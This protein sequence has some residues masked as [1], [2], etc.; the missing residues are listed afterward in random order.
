MNK[1]KI[2]KQSIYGFTMVELLIVVVVL[3]LLTL[4]SGTTYLAT[5]KTA[6]DGKR[7]VDL[8]NIRSA[9]EV[10]KSD[11]STYPILSSGPGPSTTLSTYLDPSSGKKYI[12]MPTDPKN[13]S[14]YYYVQA[15]CTTFTSGQEV[16]NSYILAVTL[17]NSPSTVPSGTCS[18][19]KTPDGTAYA[20]RDTTGA[21]TK[22]SYCLDPY[23]QISVSASDTQDAIQNPG[24]TLIT[25][26]PN[27][28]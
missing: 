7:K 6:R 2:S 3:A 20:C 25:L 24:E 12:T 16:C 21:P 10:Y 11:N 9:L 28:E 18:G 4:V 13:H 1:I 8:E 15:D 5:M 14:D 27:S 23:G 19:L 26:P 22:C 17:E